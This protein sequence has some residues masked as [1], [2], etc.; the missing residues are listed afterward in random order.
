[1]LLQFQHV[2]LSILVTSLSGEAG[3][4]SHLCLLADIGSIVVAATRVTRKGV[5]I[6]HI[7]VTITQLRKSVERSGAFGVHSM[8]CRVSGF[9]AVLR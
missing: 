4:G 3:A 8:S 1:M 6:G 7:C 5:S 2:S 9:S